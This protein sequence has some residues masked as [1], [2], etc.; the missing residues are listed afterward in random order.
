MRYRRNRQ[1]GGCYFFTL[2]LADRSQSLLT[3]N[4]SILRAAFSKV[5]RERPFRIDAIVIMP[6]HLHIVM[7]LPPGDADYSTRWMLI[8]SYFSKSIPKTESI[9]PSRKLKGERGVWQRRFWEHTIHNEFDLVKHVDYIHYN[10]V[11][12]GYVDAP[13]KWPFSSIHKY[14]RDGKIPSDW[15]YVSINLDPVRRGAEG[16][17]NLDPVGWGAEDSVNLDPVGWGAEGTPTYRD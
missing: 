8:K 11:K 15:G 13:S 7:T 14:I 16:S 5:Q 6:E 17:V 12:H 4:I 10:P 3:D 9:S 2:T 1:A